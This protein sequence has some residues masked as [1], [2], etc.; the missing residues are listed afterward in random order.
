M[1]RRGARAERLAVDLAVGVAEHKSIG[2]ALAI[3]ER[4]AEHKPDDVHPEHEPKYKPDDIAVD[5]PERKPVDQPVH[6]AERQSKREPVLVAVGE[7]CI[8]PPAVREPEREPDGVAVRVA[9]QLALAKPNAAMRPGWALP[10][11]R[12]VR[13]ELR[14][15]SL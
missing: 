8:Q 7:R 2:V 10:A 9:V 5:K 4:I 3:A 14:L 13:D 6:V 1:L 15:P 11:R 12:R